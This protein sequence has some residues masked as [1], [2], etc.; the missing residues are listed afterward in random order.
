M[1]AEIVSDVSLFLETID[2]DVV[3]PDAAANQLELL[4]YRLS[5]LSDD[6]KQR[7]AR[8]FERVAAKVENDEPCESRF[9]GCRTRLAFSTRSEGASGSTWA[10]SDLEVYWSLTG[11]AARRDTRP[12]GGDVDRVR[13]DRR[14][15]GRRL[16]GA[17]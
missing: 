1:L 9:S 7:L 17:V 6:D 3:D 8:A 12:A 4:G 13:P 2:E 10:S 5:A 14:R 15:R 16:K 11:T